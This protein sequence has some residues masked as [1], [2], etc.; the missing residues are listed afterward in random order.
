MPAKETRTWTVTTHFDNE[1]DAGRAALAPN[2]DKPNA[3]AKYVCSHCGGHWP[4]ISEMG[5]YK[6]PASLK[7]YRTLVES[8][9]YKLNGYCCDATKVECEREPLVIG[10]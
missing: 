2:A 8:A 3:H 10:G 4:I 7:W 6:R 9:R 1:A 5:L